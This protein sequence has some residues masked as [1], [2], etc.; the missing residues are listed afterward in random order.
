[1]ILCFF[2]C[3]I[4]GFQRFYDL[5]RRRYDLINDDMCV[6]D[7]RGSGEFYENITWNGILFLNG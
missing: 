6:N 3:F 1:M 5:M 4:W 7:L 2:L